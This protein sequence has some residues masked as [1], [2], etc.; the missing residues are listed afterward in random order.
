MA[1]LRRKARGRR[2]FGVR[3]GRKGDSRRVQEVVEG[4]AS[5]AEGCVTVWD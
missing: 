2:V 3:E 1:E 5:C 4:W